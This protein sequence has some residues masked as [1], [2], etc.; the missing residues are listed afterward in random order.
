MAA[1]NKNNKNNKANANAASKDRN[2][3]NGRNIGVRVMAFLMIGIMLLFTFAYAGMF[4][5]D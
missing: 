5:V 4:M 3:K 2:A 1:K